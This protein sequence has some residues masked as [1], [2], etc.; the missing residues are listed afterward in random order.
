MTPTDSVVVEEEMRSNSKALSTVPCSKGWTR[1]WLPELL[2]VVILN[3]S[4]THRPHF[5]DGQLQL[6]PVKRVAPGF[7]NNQQDSDPSTTC[8]ATC[9]MKTRDAL[10]KRQG[11][12]Y[13]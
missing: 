6:H 7:P 11:E 13:H 10:L 8:K 2:L 12:K 4:V 5:P 3:N 1:I 9:K